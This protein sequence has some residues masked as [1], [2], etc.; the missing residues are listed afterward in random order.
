MK[1]R[2]LRKPVLV[3][4]KVVVAGGL[5]ALVIA[6]VHWNDYAVA[7]DGI[8]VRAR[9]Y[10]GVP[11][12][13]KPQGQYVA[14]S[15]EQFRPI[16]MRTGEGK[17]AMIIAARPDWN[18]P[19]SYQVHLE[20]RTKWLDAGELVPDS[21]E[22]VNRGFRTTVLSARPGLMA[23]SFV[24]FLLPVL[25]LSVRWW[26]LLRIQE[27]HVSV[28][29]AVRL[30]FLGT[31]FSYVVPG[32]VSGDLIKAYYVAKHTPRKAATL[33]T[34]FVD[35]A[36]GLL[37]F[38]LLPAIV[39]AVMFATNAPG[40][41]RLTLPGLMVAA[42]LAGVVVALAL[43]L[44]PRLRGALR[45]QKLARRLPMQRHLEVVREAAQLYRRRWQAL[46]KALVMT[47]G[48]QAIFISGIFLAG[49]SLSM[50]VPWFQYFLYVPLIYIIAAVPIS[51]GGLGLTEAFF[52]TF[53]T[54]AGPS[55]SEV[56]ALALVARLFPMIVSLP[57]IVVALTGA[58]LPKA[59]Q[60]QAELEEQPPG[61][62][63]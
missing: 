37:E 39:I 41:E 31:F 50:H 60:M 27:I 24:C 13:Q 20:G 58:K 63:P 44:S 55:P 21:A 35:R 12:V 56:L 25:I 10:D 7:L 19:Q 15:Q 23:L 9:V 59:A 4:V 33:V 53:F 46:A 38:A 61:N 30:T 17:Q 16:S 22:Y 14:L 48:G 6:Q 26:Y 57:G 51:P 1:A 11:Q 5:L 34:V 47:F 36:V 29:E 3:A 62:R 40:R 28:W 42:V 49:T 52:V 54:P 45:L 8:K 43:L 32:T 18:S 2:K